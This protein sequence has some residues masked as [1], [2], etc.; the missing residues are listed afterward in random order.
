MLEELRAYPAPARRAR[1]QPYS[2]ELTTVAN[3]AVET[4]SALCCSTILPSGKYWL[5]VMA[6]SDVD[7]CTDSRQV[8]IDS[9]AATYSSG[10]PQQFPAAFL[11]SQGLLNACLVLI[12]QATTGSRFVRYKRYSSQWPA[13]NDDQPGR[14][15]A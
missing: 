15:H 14:Q 12:N 13:R 5:A 8:S 6:K 9:A 4:S 11:Q 1:P 10:V 3:T 2:D 7:V